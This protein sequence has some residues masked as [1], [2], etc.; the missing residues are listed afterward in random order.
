MRENEWKC[1]K[2]ELRFG[3]PLKLRIPKTTFNKNLLHKLR[4]LVGL[5]ISPMGTSTSKE[6]TPDKVEQQAPATE[7]EDDEPDEW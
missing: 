2:C 7:P 4:Q 5:M 6:V 1:V 3:R